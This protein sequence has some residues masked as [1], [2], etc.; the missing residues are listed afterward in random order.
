MNSDA[1]TDRI[2]ANADLVVWAMELMKT[3]IFEPTEMHGWVRAVKMACDD[4]VAARIEQWHN[5]GY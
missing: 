1:Y 3:S 2:Q 5:R 4:M